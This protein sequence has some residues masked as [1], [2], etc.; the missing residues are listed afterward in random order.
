MTNETATA[1][2]WGWNPIIDKMDAAHCRKM[3]AM[4]ANTLAWI[5]WTDADIRQM[6]R[7]AGE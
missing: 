1:A 2:A 6:A 5:G 4:G 3:I 7:K